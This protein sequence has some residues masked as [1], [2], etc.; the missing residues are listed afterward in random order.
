MYLLSSPPKRQAALSK[1]NPY[2]VSRTPSFFETAPRLGNNFP[3]L[4]SFTSR[5]KNQ[6]TFQTGFDK[7]LFCGTEKVSF[8]QYN[9]MRKLVFAIECGYVHTFITKRQ[10]CNQQPYCTLIYACFNFIHVFFSWIA[11]ICLAPT[12]YGDGDTSTCNNQF[13]GP[14]F[15]GRSAT[16]QFVSEQ[17]GFRCQGGY[18]N[19][20]LSI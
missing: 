3:F 16:C 1:W 8:L 19:E 12:C 18:F 5:E 14:Q 10:T 2:Q 9:D 7:R 13:L 11:C 6:L 4:D 17:C 20:C 15:L